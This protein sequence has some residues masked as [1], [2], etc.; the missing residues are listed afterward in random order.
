[1]VNIKNLNE[2]NE[3][4]TINENNQNIVLYRQ[5]KYANDKNTEHSCKMDIIMMIMFCF[6]IFLFIIAYETLINIPLSIGNTNIELSE[7]IKEDL[8]DSGYFSI[9]ILSYIKI[10]LGINNNSFKTIQSTSEQIIK[11][12]FSFLIKTAQDNSDQ[13]VTTCT[14]GNKDSYIGLFRGATNFIFNNKASTDCMIHV[15]QSSVDL[16]TTQ[17]KYN[18]NLLLNTLKFSS[19]S[20]TSYISY[21]TKTLFITST[22]F[23]YR[24]KDL[25]QKSL[26][27]KNNEN[28]L[29]S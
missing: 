20:I 10:I 22:Y 11:T 4:Y 3:N 26:Q 27:E 5:Q 15:S 16:I 23:I 28:M 7:K 19:D 13:V 18:M 2:D 14:I 17:A 29:V 24:I 8:E 9:D 21:G 1:M 25:R 6:S 12:T